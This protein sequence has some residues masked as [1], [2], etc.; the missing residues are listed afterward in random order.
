M[1]NANI[2]TKHAMPNETVITRTNKTEIRSTEFPRA[3]ETNGNNIS[4]K[5][6]KLIYD[7]V[8]NVI[9]D[10]KG[11]TLTFNDIYTLTTDDTNLV[12]INY[13]NVIYRLV[14]FDGSAIEFSNSYL[15]GRTEWFGRII[16]NVENNVKFDE[17]PCDTYSEEETIIGKWID[18]RPIYRTLI[19]LGSIKIRS[20]ASVYNSISKSQFDWTNVDKIT[21]GWIFGDSFSLFAPVHMWMDPTGSYS[22]VG[23]QPSLF[24]APMYEIGDGY[25]KTLVLEY[26]KTTD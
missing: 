2:E 14:F 19:S 16:I 7:D 20:G 12:T 22:G 3:N 5:A 21:N 17:I 4:L 10:E 24:Y 1:F 11:K 23:G 15:Y 6:V 8:D 13:S 25:E 18:G 9:K 26:T